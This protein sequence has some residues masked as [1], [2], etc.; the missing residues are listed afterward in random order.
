VYSALYFQGSG[1]TYDKH[2]LLLGVGVLARFLNDRLG[3]P[4]PFTFRLLLILGDVGLTLLVAEAAFRRTANLRLGFLLG[5]GYSL[6]PI[7]LAVF[8]HSQVDS[9]ALL[10]IVAAW[11]CLRWQGRNRW[12]PLAAGALLGLGAAIK[13]FAFV[14]LPWLLFEIK[15]WGKRLVFLAA[16]A[17]FFLLPIGLYPDPAQA[18]KLTF[19][20]TGG[21][22][23][24][25][26]ITLLPG[27]FRAANTV[28]MKIGH[29]PWFHPEWFGPL[30]TWKWGPF[31]ASMLS[32]LAAGAVLFFTRLRRLSSLHVW[33]LLCLTL[34]TFGHNIAPQYWSWPIAAGLIVVL[35]RPEHRF[36]LL[37]FTLSAGLVYWLSLLVDRNLLAPLLG[38]SWNIPWSAGWLAA[39]GLRLP[40]WLFCCLWWWQTAVRMKTET[41]LP[42]GSSR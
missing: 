24:G 28:L 5:L 25:W 17:S 20:Y 4:F 23:E 26:G 16:A 14:P 8:V 37:G 27:I 1:F 41:I 40:L 33:L 7:I 3:Y 39:L 19:S 36:W 11:A 22:Y 38:W 6:N 21:G 15:G 9:L 30:E 2:P 12:S 31:N 29:A 42:E 32:L 13:Y 18:L 10:G 35:D 34:F